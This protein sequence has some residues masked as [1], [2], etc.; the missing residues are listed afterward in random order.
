MAYKP[1][2]YI[3]VVFIINSCT[4]ENTG[5]PEFIT[6]GN[7]D[8]GTMIRKSIDTTFTN[9]N[10]GEF[11]SYNFHFNNDSQTE[12]VL[13]VTN[14]NQSQVKYE[15]I[16]LT[17]NN[18]SV[19]STTLNRTDYWSGQTKNTS[20]IVAQLVEQNTIIKRDTLWYTNQDIGVFYY[21]FCADC[22]GVAWTKYGKERIVE[23]YIPIAVTR[24]QSTQLG[25]IKLSYDFS[26]TEP[27]SL[28]IHEFCIQK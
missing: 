9:T 28:T 27:N 16:Y 17:L 21:H 4:K 13:N 7:F 1:I 12:I 25:W 8:A 22:A 20:T 5:R 15:Y 2:I 3:L 6:V 24:N 19:L 11:G 14:Y 10:I 26:G 23:G 18:S